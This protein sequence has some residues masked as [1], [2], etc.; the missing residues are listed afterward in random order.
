MT[1]VDEC[2]CGLTV[3]YIESCR[4]MT[5]QSVIVRITCENWGGVPVGCIP[6]A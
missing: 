6:D 5:N 3:M 4:Y 2:K 1:Q